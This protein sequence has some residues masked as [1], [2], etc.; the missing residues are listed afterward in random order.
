M[1][2]IELREICNYICEK[3]CLLI[4]DA[5]LL[6]L[7]GA[8]GAGKTTLLNVISGLCAYTG[9]VC[10]DHVPVDNLP[11]AKRNVGY[12]FQSFALF[13]HLN[14]RNNIAFGLHA[15][16]I[17]KAQTD[18][19]VL[20]LAGRLRI[21]HLLDRYPGSLSGGE[22]QR[23]ALARTLAPHPKILLLDEPFNSLDARTAGYLRQELKDLQK[24][25][26]LTTVYVTHNQKE[27][28]EMGHRI[29]VINGGNVEQV[30]RPEEILFNPETSSVF[31]LFGSPAI[32]ACNRI[33]G[34]DF[35]LGK[36]M[37][38][39]LTLIVPYEGTPLKKI[40]VLPA[41]VR[42]SPYP[43]EN[44]IPNRFRGYIAAERRNP[45][46]VRVDVRLEGAVITAEL[47]ESQW[48]QMGLDVESPAYLGVPLESIRTLA[49][50]FPVRS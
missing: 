11:P 17:P 13:P 38:G 2:C 6:V 36:A 24:Q 33:D 46:V 12:L 25:M 32:F 27:A 34:L 15:R 49:D 7:A 10:F 50:D 5:E 48:D 8:T 28:F 14:V 9:S 42:I 16:Q 20:E 21:S 39:S 26:G 19:R 29:A 18:Q 47:A 31:R 41:G 23:V 35:G 43:V 30:A 4:R 37:C 22:K 44:H 40:A 1:A 3:T 45:P